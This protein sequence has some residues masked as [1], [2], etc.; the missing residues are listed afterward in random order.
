MRIY[1][2]DGELKEY[3][4]LAMWDNEGFIQ[5][6]LPI[7]YIVDAKYGYTN[8]VKKF[9]DIEDEN[10]KAVVYTNSLLALNNRLAW[11]ENLKV[12]E[13]YLRI[14]SAFK[15]IDKLTNRELKQGHNI[16]KMYI[17]GEFKV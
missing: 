4:E 2:E 9:I 10:N 1:F 6:I 17:A 8:N 13:I 7:H 14:G 16:M 3:N 15:R 5:I 12:P 11:N